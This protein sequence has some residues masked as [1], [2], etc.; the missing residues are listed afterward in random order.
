VSLKETFTGLRGLWEGLRRGLGARLEAK[1]T[2]LVSEVQET[3]ELT[4]E[5]SV[6]A[7]TPAAIHD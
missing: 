3:P 6:G 4:P 5:R 2:T 1:P 7:G